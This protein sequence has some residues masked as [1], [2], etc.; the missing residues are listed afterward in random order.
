M[1]SSGH[2]SIDDVYVSAQSCFAYMK[3]I[4]GRFKTEKSMVKLYDD[5]FDGYKITRKYFREH[6][7]V[8]RKRKA[9]RR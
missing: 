2:I 5:L 7:E 3:R 6:P 9:V 8:K 1:V 4:H